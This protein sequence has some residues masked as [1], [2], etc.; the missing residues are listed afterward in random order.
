[1]IRFRRWICRV[2]L[3]TGQAEMVKAGALPVSKR[4]HDVIAR[5]LLFPPG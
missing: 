2:N 4:E 5:I 1:M 3:Y